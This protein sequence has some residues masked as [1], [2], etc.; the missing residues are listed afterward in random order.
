MTFSI[1]AYIG[2]ETAIPVLS[3]VAAVLGTMMMLGKTVLRFLWIRFL[4]L[5]RTRLPGEEPECVESA[6][7]SNT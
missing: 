5:F 4:G 7:T 3:A 1:I 2:P 6:G